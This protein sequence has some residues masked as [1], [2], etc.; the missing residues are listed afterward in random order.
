MQVV[1]NRFRTVHAAGIQAT[2][3]N[4]LIAIAASLVA[5]ASWTTLLQDMQFYSLIAYQFAGEQLI[6]LVLRSSTCFV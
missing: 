4:H 6:D 5:Y 3:L 2:V 1:S